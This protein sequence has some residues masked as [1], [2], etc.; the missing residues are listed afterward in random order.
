ML[1]RLFASLRPQCRWRVRV[2]SCSCDRTCREVVCVKHSHIF[3]QRHLMEID[4]KAL[5]VG[6]HDAR[7]RPVK[8]KDSDR[9]YLA[10][11]GP[12]EGQL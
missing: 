11:P 5:K 6:L 10:F 2:Q 4:A 1:R 9:I 3:H 8:C 7:V 12:P